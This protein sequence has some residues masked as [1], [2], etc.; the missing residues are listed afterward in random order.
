MGNTVFGR[1]REKVTGSWRRLHSRMMGV[2]SATDVIGIMKSR[3]VRLV[4]AC[5]TAM[6]EEK[7]IHPF[8]GKP[9]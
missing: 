9:Q 3:G 7:F 1:E 4:G 8:R 6:R 5:S 2:S